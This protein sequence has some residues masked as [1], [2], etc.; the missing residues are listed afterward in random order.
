VGS[1][2]SGLGVESWSDAKDR[3]IERQMPEIV[4]ALLYRAERTL[5]GQAEWSYQRRL[6]LRERALQKQ[7]AERREQERRCQEAIAARKQQI[8]QETLK[9]AEDQKAA[10][11]IRQLVEALKEH[12]DLG[13]DQQEQFGHWREEALR[14]ADLLD[15]MKRPLIDVLG[16][17]GRRSEAPILTP[18]S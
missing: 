11:E 13:P 14:L 17:L 1:A 18:G 6:E 7:E 9:L 3:K 12:P 8:R 16:T 2:S 4:R 10:R 15:P 5:R